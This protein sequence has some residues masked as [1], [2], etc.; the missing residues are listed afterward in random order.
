M[1]IDVVKQMYDAFEEG[2]F[3]RMLSLVSEDCQWDHRGPPGVPIGQLYVG[4]DGVGEFFETFTETQETLEF[5][6]REF[7]GHGDRVVVLGHHRFRVKETG[8]EWASDFAMTW[9]VKDGKVTHWRPI[10]DMSAEAEAYRP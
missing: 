8:K 2:D 9:T 6:P 10:H 1:S 5:D 3:P 7:F 4:P